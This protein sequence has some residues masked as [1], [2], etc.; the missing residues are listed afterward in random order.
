[1]EQ[2]TKGSLWKTLEDHSQS[3]GLYTPQN[4]INNST[5]NRQQFSASACD[6]QLDYSKQHITNDTLALL[7]S[8]A[9]KCNLKDKIHGLMR[10]DKLNISENRAALHTALRVFDDTQ[11]IVNHQNIMPE[12]IAARN[13]MQNIVE[14][15]RE[16]IWL[17]FSG[18]PIT[19]IVNIGIGGSDLGPRFSLKALAEFTAKDMN[20]HFIY[21]VDPNSFSNTV[22]K[23]NPET[24]LFIVSSK[25][26][27]T[28]ETLYNAKKAMNWIGKQ[29]HHAKH[30]I[31]VTA[32]PKKAHQFGIQTVLPIWDWVGGRYSFCSAINLI[33]AI[34]I[35][36]EHFNQLLA[37][38]NSM[39]RHF[40]ESDFSTNLPVLLALL[41]IWNNNF[42][43][44]HN[45]LIL[46]Y[47]ERL[48]QFVPY[49]QQLDME[50]NGKS[51]DNKGKTV[52]HATGPIIWGGMGNQAQHSYYQLLCQ[53]THKV[54]ADFISLNAFD[55]QIINKMCD[56]KIN[57]LTAGVNDQENQNG[58]IP[59]NTPLNH[60]RINN[61]SPFSIG[62]LV[63]L[64]EHKVFVQSVI[65]DINPFDQP[66][67]ESAK[68]N[69]FRHMEHA[70][71]EAMTESML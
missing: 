43:H 47:S 5:V 61:Y 49:I 38:A 58:Y 66:G 69:Y 50:S 28:Q 14:Q 11:I 7:I 35:G 10:G 64:Y 65:W 32:Q 51:I 70:A 39:D 37:G 71:T 57:V 25:S 19:D 44:I 68:H 2:V 30:F 23:L 45:L 21:D 24:T 54:T 41:G 53:G 42:L 55:G 62:A 52:N 12:I 27:T 48:E 16:K 67:V 40:K 29:Q 63:A 60:I 15:I 9:N 3:L 8:L 31:A 26:F 18:K 56:A 4:V 13:K 20:Y 59:G 34:A 33:T 6:I 17:G 1:M 36:F 46:T 22:S